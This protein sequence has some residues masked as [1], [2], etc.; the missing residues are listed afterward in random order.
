ML[1]AALAVPI[2]VAAPTSSFKG[3]VTG[4]E[5]SKI[6]IIWMQLTRLLQASETLCRRSMT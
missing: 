4:D 2:A 3:A 1:V 6:R 5:N